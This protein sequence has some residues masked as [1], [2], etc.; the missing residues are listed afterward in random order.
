VLENGRIAASGLSGDLKSDP[1][2]RE[3]YLG[4]SALKKMHGVMS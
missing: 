1:K 4:G 3:A 2:I